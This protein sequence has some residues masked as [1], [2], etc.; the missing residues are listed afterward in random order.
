MAETAK[1]DRE[2]AQQKAGGGP[3]WGRVLGSVLA[4]MFGVQSG[5]NRERDFAQGRPWVYV[6]VGLVVTIVFVLSVWTVVRLVL[7]SA[8]A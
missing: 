3:S 6:V 4:S 5:R 1:E 2:M 7:K 8:G